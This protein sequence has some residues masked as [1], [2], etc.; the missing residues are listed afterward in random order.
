MEKVIYL[1]T[2]VGHLPDW[3]TTDVLCSAREAFADP[4][5]RGVSLHLP[6]RDIEDQ[7][8]KARGAVLTHTGDQSSRPLARQLVALVSLWMDS[9][10]D[11]EDATSF[12]TGIAED[13]AAYTVTESVTRW[14][15]GPEGVPGGVNAVS[16]LRRNQDMSHEQFLRHW[17]EVHMPISL[18]YHPQWKYVRNPLVRTIIGDPREAPDAIAEEGFA[19]SADLIDPMRF[20]GAVDGDSET[21]A[22]NRAIVFEDVPVFL[23]TSATTTFVTEEHVIRA[24]WSP[25]AD[26]RDETARPPAMHGRN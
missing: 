24:A 5:Y 21:L 13:V 9:A 11:L 3:P 2:R 17:A 10:D 18:R 15:G 14:W 26:D 12:V 20:Y 7:R 25:R 22:R 1:A 16:L 23:D 4:R 8:Q 19:T 6:R